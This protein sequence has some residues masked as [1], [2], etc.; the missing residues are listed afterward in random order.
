MIDMFKKNIKKY[1]LI[2]FLALGI[3][4]GGIGVPSSM[5]TVA[6][7][8]N[9]LNEVT[10]NLNLRAGPGTGY[11][12]LGIIHQ[13]H[14]FRVTRS[15]GVWRFGTVAGGANAGR[16]GWVHSNYLRFIACT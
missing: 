16:Q 11:A 13:G 15:Q 4:L 14:S 7:A 9:S 1:I 12:S 10:A 2:P 8:C 6:Y 5:P 3:I